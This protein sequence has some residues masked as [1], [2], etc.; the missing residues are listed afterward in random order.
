MTAA[1]RQDN[2]AGRGGWWL[3]AALIGVALL[4]PA[5][6]VQAA[7]RFTLTSAIPDDVFIVTGS[8]YNPEQ[9]FLH[10]EWNEVW[11]EFVASGVMD[12]VAELFLSA[13][14]EQQK[15]ELDRV[16]GSFKQLVDA[17][18]WE[19]M[20]QGEVAFAERLNVPV[21]S[22]ENLNFGTPDMVCL[23]RMD[24]ETAAKN[25]V[26]LT[27]ILEGIVA[28]TNQLLGTQL[29]TTATIAGSEDGIR[30][31]TFNPMQM[32]PE[33]PQMPI[34]IGL[35]D[36]VLFMSMGAPITKQVVGLLLGDDRTTSIASQPRFQAAFERLPEPEDGFEFV[37]LARLHGDLDQILDA[38]FEMVDS[39]M[40]R[41]QPAA[42]D[43][44]P[45]EDEMIFNAVRSVAGRV[46]GI[47]GMF[48]WAAT[49]RHTDGRSTFSES[50]TSLTQDASTHPF[51]KVM[52][53]APQVD[54]FARFLPRETRT[55][56]VNSGA[57]M[58]ALCAFLEGLVSD[59]GQPG[60]MAMAAWEGFQQE[61]G[62]NVQ[63]DI[64]SWIEGS[65][66]NATF[67]V[68]GRS[69]WV[70][71]MKVKDEEKARTQ[72]AKGL[73]AGLKKLSEL[74]A[75]YPQLAMMALT[76]SPVTDE[77]LAGFHRIVF[78]LSPE[79]TICGVRDGWMVFASSTDAV[80]RVLATGRGEHPNV[81]ENEALMASALVPE[82]TAELVSF[83]DHSKDAEEMAGAL[84]AMSMMGGMASM[85]IPDPKGRQMIS[86]VT[87]MLAKLAPVVAAIDFYQS[88][89]SYTTFDGN[90]WTVRNVTHYVPAAPAA[91]AAEEVGGG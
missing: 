80:K 68:D 78:T 44:G 54:D 14:N 73:D 39:Q 1:V 64:I 79:P 7:D 4:G 66:V 81:R 63:E 59:L 88:S 65:G 70:S 28:E 41:K 40:A 76:A 82:G 89:S 32:V 83:T 38:V 60:Q 57:D 2:S 34:S 69:A 67:D 45:S 29:K 47:V 10:E 56:S 50:I 8:R 25:F 74:S 42:A 53:G 37:D 26:G 19:G 90:S 84:G 20:G 13:M 85:A 24:Q 6:P 12:D 27:G 55:Y 23:F 17:V 36:D 58:D 51:Y 21:F 72:L 30:L 15:A 52:V 11:E 35:H 77:D 46:V 61:A 16:T 5:A 71:L 87:G 48:D 31:V 22:G 75:D 33:A 18:D 62:L 86:K 9:Q 49:V 91:P 3:G 43:Q